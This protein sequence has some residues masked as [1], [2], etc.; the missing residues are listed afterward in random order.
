MEGEARH[1]SVLR[2]FLERQGFLVAHN[3]LS[4]DCITQFSQ[5][6]WAMPTKCS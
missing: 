2:V 4:F 6:A 5:S 1:D 3:P